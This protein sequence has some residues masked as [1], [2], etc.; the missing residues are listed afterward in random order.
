MC[1]P[2]EWRAPIDAGC[3]SPET[4]SILHCS[5]PYLSSDHVGRIGWRFV[6]HVEL[7]NPSRAYIFFFNTFCN[8][9]DG[10]RSLNLYLANF[11]RCVLLFLNTLTVGALI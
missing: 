8:F 5:R 6:K 4:D 11:R 1:V 9:T 10:T 2:S 7:S 3:L